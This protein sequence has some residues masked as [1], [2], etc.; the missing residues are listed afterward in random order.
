[1]SK[2]RELEAQLRQAQKLEALGSLAGGIAHDFNNILASVIGYTELAQTEVAQTSLAQP[3]LQHVLTAGLRA[4]ALVRQILA[5]SRRTPLQRTPIALADVLRET[6]PFLQ[7]LLPATITLEA[8]LTPEASLVLADET[9]MHQIVMNLGANAAYAMRDTG[10]VLTV[11]L[12]AVEV[13]TPL[14]ATHPAL[15]PGPYMQLTM[16]DS[17]PGIPP[18]VIQRMYD[19]F[20][21]TKALGQGTGLGLSVVHRIVESHGG[22]ILVESTLGQRTMFMIYLPRIVTPAAGAPSPASEQRLLKDD[23]LPASPHDPR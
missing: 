10:G 23:N 13:D 15:R 1:V 5:F 20:F 19:P 14:A 11:R 22:T 4:K 3:W 16:R 21:T 6:L 17:G 7:A 12:E 8:H 18:D 9:Q 2:T